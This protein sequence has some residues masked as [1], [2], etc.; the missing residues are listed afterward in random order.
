MAFE[1]QTQWLKLNGMPRGELTFFNIYVF[2]DSQPL[3]I[4]CEKKRHFAIGKGHLQLIIY[5]V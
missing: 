3:Q 4:H 5:I 2:N 1:N